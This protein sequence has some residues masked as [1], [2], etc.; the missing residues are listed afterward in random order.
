MCGA[1]ASY[2]HTQPGSTPC[3]LNTVNLLS[4][5]ATRG[6]A[7]VHCGERATLDPSQDT[8]LCRRAEGCH[9]V[10][11][12]EAGLPGRAAVGMLGKGGRGG[13]PGVAGRL[14][15]QDSKLSCYTRAC[16]SGH[17]RGMG[18]WMTA[19]AHGT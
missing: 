8:R 15:V 18:C 11:G 17:A 2:R 10:V 4:E 19:S 3:K 13:I 14:R 6:G 7:H 12:R 5:G 9:R 1:V 16:C